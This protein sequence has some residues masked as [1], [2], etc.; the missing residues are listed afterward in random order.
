M[1]R[2]HRAHQ[3]VFGSGVMALHG[4]LTALHV[5]HLAGVATVGQTAHAIAIG[6]VIGAGSSEQRERRCQQRQN[7]KEAFEAS[8]RR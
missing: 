1:T 2:A 3:H 5:L 8:H 7:H 6:H 4:V